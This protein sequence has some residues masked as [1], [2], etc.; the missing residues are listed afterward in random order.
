MVYSD[1]KII[2]CNAVRTN[3][4][5]QTVSHHAVWL[6]IRRYPNGDTKYFLTNAPDN[7]Q[8]QELHEAATL[9]WPIEQCFEECKSHLGMADFEG[10]SYNGF[11]R[12]LL[13]V[14]IAHFF[15][16]SLRLTLK[17]TIFP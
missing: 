11:M 16:T 8:P 2:R 3:D 6:Y 10:R 14:M 12:H 5:N 15:S 7:I 13:F 17:K 1:I 9:R 4:K